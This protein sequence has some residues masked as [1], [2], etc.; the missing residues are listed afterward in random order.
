[1]RAKPFCI[2]IILFISRTSLADFTIYTNRDQWQ[3]ATGRSTAITFVGYPEFTT[4]TDQ[5]AEHGI[6]FTDGN[7]F[8]SL[9]A[10]YPSDGA[11]LVSAA[12]ILV[13]E[14]GVYMEFAEPRTSI[15]FDYI[16]RIKFEFYL[17]GQLIHMTNH[18]SS[19]NTPFVGL[20][21]SSP[22]DRVLAWDPFDAVV[23]IDNL[24][25][26][27]PVP[28]T[29]SM[30]VVAIGVLMNRRRPRTNQTART[31]NYEHRSRRRQQLFALADRFI[32]G[33]GHLL[34]AGV[35]AIHRHQQADAERREHPAGSA[36]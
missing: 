2:I 20:I 26:G 7:D 17:D 19:G 4:I 21:S 18:F 25:F 27:D 30:L 28:S 1:M 12:D 11:G 23:A 32:D 8:I 31:T 33:V 36:R 14:S 3:S 29:G 34:V 6:F 22:F 13:P 35:L 10:S 5:Y 9:S 15:A 16:G 24:H